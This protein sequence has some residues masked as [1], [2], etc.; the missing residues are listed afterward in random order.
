MELTTNTPSTTTAAEYIYMCPEQ[1]RCK[2]VTKLPVRVQQTALAW[3]LPS[4]RAAQ[5]KHISDQSSKTKEV[6]NKT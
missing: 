1:A 5:F 4:V 3:V 2:H 6:H